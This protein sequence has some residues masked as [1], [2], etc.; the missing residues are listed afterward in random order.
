MVSQP[1]YLEQI[2]F[3]IL[4]KGVCEVIFSLFSKKKKIIKEFYCFDVYFLLCIIVIQFLFIW[5]KYIAISLKSINLSHYRRL[6]II[7]MLAEMKYLINYLKPKYQWSLL[8]LQR[9]TSL[10]GIEYLWICF[11]SLWIQMCI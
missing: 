11:Q 7:D 4:Y 6:F 10:C 1:K 8:W 3:S 5:I 9:P 2:W